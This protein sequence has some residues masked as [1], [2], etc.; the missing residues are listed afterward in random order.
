MAGICADRNSL[1]MLENR[2]ML[3]K[4]LWVFNLELV[5]PEDDWF[6]KS[7]SALMWSQPELFVR[8][9]K[10]GGIAVPPIDG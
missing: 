7:R 9:T 2:L 4:I 8:L 10:R 5:D 3:T 6:G 1:A